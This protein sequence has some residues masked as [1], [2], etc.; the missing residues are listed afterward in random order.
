[1]KAAVLTEAGSA[2]RFTHFAG[3]VMDFGALPP[4]INSARIY[5]G[6]G[7]APMLAAAA[8]WDDL[9]EDLYSTAASYSSVVSGLTSDAWLGPSSASMAAAAATYLAWMSSTAGQ[10]EQTANQARA[11]AAAYETAFAMT[12]PPPV[13][14]ANRS[15]LAALVATNFLGQNTPAIVATDAHYAEMWAQDAAAMYGYAGSSASATQLTPFTAPGPTTNAGGLA[16]QSAAV[17]QAAGSAP[18]TSAHTVM[19]TAPQL[20]SAVPQALQSLASSTSTSTSSS[21][22]LVDLLASL[23]PYAGVVAGGI[24]T[25]GAGVG[26][27]A[28]SVGMV[29]IVLGIVGTAAQAS[30]MAAGGGGATGSTLLAAGGGGSV[31]GVLVDRIGAGT[32]ASASLGGA[33][34]AGALPVPPSWTAA[35]PSAPPVATVSDIT[36][37]AEPISTNMPP[38]MWSALPM[39]QLA[40]RGTTPRYRTPQRDARHGNINAH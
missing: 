37:A 16:A 2:P 31:T 38:A 25:V 26:S 32:A 21:S 12:V 23:A 14:A 35:A 11:A 28:G 3:A 22:S 24:G 17:T 36:L 5:A 9:A 8:A 4:E 33:G 19:S 34:T 20:V 29:D 39:A 13:I 10:A 18:G 27:G 30:L 15:L 7:S 6:P 40:G 1:M